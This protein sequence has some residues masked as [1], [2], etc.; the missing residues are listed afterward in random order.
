MVEVKE[1]VYVSEVDFFKKIEESISYDIEQSVGKKI[2]PYKG[3]KYTKKMKSKMGR[4]GNVE[5]LIKEFKP[6]ICYSA[7]FKS[8]NGINEISYTIDKIEDYCIDVIY[9]ESFQG[10]KTSYNLNYKLMN[11]FYKNR[12]KKRARRMIKAIEAYLQQ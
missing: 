1:R 5:I 8:L 6:P 4:K 2:K 3:Y 10:N 9:K 12:A 11:F 7:S